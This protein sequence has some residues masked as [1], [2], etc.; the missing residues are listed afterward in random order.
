VYLIYLSCAW[1]AGIFLGTEFNLP[2]TFTLLGLVPLPL[3]FFRHHHWKAIIIT[4][5]SLITFFAAIPYS[6]SS[7][8]TIKE[9]SLQFYNDSGNREIK[10][11]VARDPEV[12]DKSTRLYF[13]AS[14][15]KINGRW[16]E[17]KGTALLFVPRYPEYKYGDALQVVG[18]PETPPQLNDFDYKGY[19]AHQGIY[20]TSLY[21]KIEIEARGKG[22]KPLDW[23]YSARERLTQALTKILPEPQASLAQGLILGIRTNIPQPVKT[24]F[25]R[26]GTAH[27]LAISG[28]NLTIV[29][30]I[31][32]SLGVWLFGRRHYLYVW[33]ALGIIWFYA[34]LTGMH[35]PVVRSAIMATLF[36]SAELLGRQKSAITALTLAAAIMVGIS[37]YI[38]GD[39]AFQ[40]SF[41]A[42]AGLVFLYPPFQSLGRKAVK[43]TLGED[44]TLVSL[45]SMTSDSF[46]A[47]LAATIAVLPLIAYYFGIV[48]FVGPLATFLALVALP[49]TIIF[50]A[51]GGLLGLFLLPLAQVI[52][53]LTWFFLT[54][55]LLIVRGLAQSP[56]SFIE[57]GKIS[58]DVI[59]IYYSVLAM[60]IWVAGNWKNL[61]TSMSKVT[62]KVG[63]GVSKL[64]AF[65][66]K[67]PKRW[68]IPPLL[69]IA[70]LVVAT[71]GSMP[72][73][74]L[75]LSFL[76]VGQGD[77]TLIQLGTQQILI[78]GGPSPQAL[79]LELS[80]QM[81]FWD[82]MIDLVVL[83]HPDS[84]HL[85]GL[86]ELLKRFQVGQVLYPDLEDKSPLFAEWLNL[87]K[88]KKITYTIAQMGQQINLGKAL[89]IA[90]L[91]PPTT[92]PT[93][94]EWDV[95]NNSVVLRLRF[96]RLSFLFTADI[97][98]EAE[99][100]LIQ[101][102]ANLTSTVL[103]V[104]HHGANTSTTKEFLNTVNPGLA[105]ISV[106]ADNKFGHPT[107]EVIARLKEKVGAENI[108][109]TDLQST[110]ELVTDGE[111]L[112][113]KTEN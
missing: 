13:A 16:Q 87:I 104:A 59:V 44:S 6:F 38:L 92:P 94:K 35:P 91:N 106:G 49:G 56:F 111:R 40:L 52:G 47:T 81:P 28:L 78:D 48:S 54:Y 5:L 69:V 98:S 110:V 103:K 58:T 99:W 43:S 62:E 31:M 88:V 70:V 32:L 22:F 21:P 37:P 68:V 50:G 10:G 84:D 79:N 3:L 14:E 12:G 30:G 17:V 73:D 113:V 45:A 89:T 1:F 108:Y 80:R 75:H 60:A 93:G 102:R 9:N 36:L 57:V 100:T 61:A 19:L 96:G 85:A 63:S 64:S 41:V 7:L 4:S 72:D 24:D 67:L 66:S 53:W 51:L 95:D 76:D 23:I 2:L 82:R 77:A 46:S 71:A 11:I 109:R 15:I 101:N 39:A 105:V 107:A 26:T 20:T 55:I 74:R 112:W 97:R 18:R 34:L 29:A 65:A 27:L 90:V 83:T 86:V 8:H 25:V 33:L 42:M